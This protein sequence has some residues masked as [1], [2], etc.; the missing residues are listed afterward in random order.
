VQRL[1]DRI[2]RMEV[3]LSEER[4]RHGVEHRAQV[5][6]L[7]PRETLRAHGEGADHFAAIDKVTDRVEMQL[8][9][10]KDRLTDRS[11]RGPKGAPPKPNDEAID[12]EAP[13]DSPI[14]RVPPQVPKPLS[15]EEARIE[16]ESRGLAFLFFT[17]AESMQGAVIYRRKT[18]FGL[19]EPES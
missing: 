13:D 8:R 7:T 17:N 2:I 18:G 19:I 16:L 12:I 4:N 6:V 14:V 3:E 5:T 10:F 15:P 9:R 1:F 11:H